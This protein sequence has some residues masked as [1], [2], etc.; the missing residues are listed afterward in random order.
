MA[1]DRLLGQEAQS[2]WRYYLPATSQ[3]MKELAGAALAVGFIFSFRHWGIGGVFDL[4]GGFINFLII[5]LLSA[6]AMYGRVFAQ[7][8][9]A[10]TE[11]FRP[12]FKI[13][14][15]GLI[16][17]LLIAFVTNGKVP[18]II[19]GGVTSTFIARHRMGEFRYG[20]NYWE[21]GIMVMMGSVT[22]MFFALVSKVGLLIFPSSFFLQKF[23][24]INIVI[25]LTMLI[26]FP[27][28]DGMDLFYASRLTWILAFG[29]MLGIGILF[30]FAGILFSILV[31]AIIGVLLWFLFYVAYER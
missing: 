15:A 25:A 20:R 8:A 11:G 16:T 28:L 26:P 1:F 24:I 4:L 7:R 18:F 12:E 19:V 29:I 9:W 22:N 5:T 13:W 14:M 21:N 31:G 3:E 6:I 2:R 30:L 23:M 27:P 17:S 10:L